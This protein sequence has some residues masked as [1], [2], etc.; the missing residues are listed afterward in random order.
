MNPPTPAQTATAQRRAAALLVHY[1]RDDS[2]GYNA[3]I[4]ETTEAGTTDAVYLTVALLEM[5]S[6]LADRA[7]GGTDRADAILVGALAAHVQQEAHA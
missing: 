4:R 7:F 5:C 2:E 1:R 3:I 6:M